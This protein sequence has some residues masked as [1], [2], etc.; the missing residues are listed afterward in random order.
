MDL[1][2]YPSIYGTAD[3]GGGGAGG[4]IGHCFRPSHDSAPLSPIEL[5]VGDEM[6]GISN[7][8]PSVE[9]TMLADGL[10]KP[11]S[12]SS[13]SRRSSSERGEEKETGQTTRSRM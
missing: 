1:H 3:G 9:N 6:S 11:K 7:G 13:L 5:L 12:S 4:Y 10:S 8:W 2:L